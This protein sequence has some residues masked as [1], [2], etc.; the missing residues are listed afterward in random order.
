MTNKTVLF[1]CRHEDGDVALC[2]K[3]EVDQFI[4]SWE[5]I[6]EDIPFETIAKILPGRVQ[7]DI[8]PNQIE[9]YKSEFLEDKALVDKVILK[10]IESLIKR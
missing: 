4:T 1:V 7:M 10:V 6:D 5:N 2:T 8:T 3:A 9:W